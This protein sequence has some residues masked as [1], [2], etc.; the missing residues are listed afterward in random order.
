LVLRVGILPRHVTA[1]DLLQGKLAE[2]LA[3][4]QSRTKIAASVL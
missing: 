1:R 3:E 2:V 4:Q